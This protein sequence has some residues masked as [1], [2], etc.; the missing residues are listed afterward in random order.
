MKE[1]TI[2]CS[3]LENAGALHK[4]LA[5]KLE[6]PDWYGNNLDALHDMLTS[7]AEDTCLTLVNPECVGRGFRRAMRD[8]EAKNPHFIVT[9]L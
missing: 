6:F 2:D 3:G 1:I 4:V 9:L 7:I 8:A 5:E